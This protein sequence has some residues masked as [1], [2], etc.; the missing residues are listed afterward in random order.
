[1]PAV[2][3]T[4][5]A[6]LFGALEFS[7]YC[8]KSGIQP[9]IGCQISLART[10]Q[11][12]H[13]ARPHRR[14][15]PKTPAGMANLQRLSSLGFTT[16]DPADP[17]LPVETLLQ[18][19]DGLFLLTGGTRGPIGRLLA[20]ARRDEAASPARPLRRSLRRPQQS[21]SCTATASPSSG[22][23][24]PVL[25]PWPTKPAFPSSPPTSASSPPRRCSEAHEA[26]LCIA[27]GR[28]LADPNRRRVTDQHWFKPAAAMRKLFADL[29]EACDNTIAIA[30]RCSVMAETRK[31][32][33]PVCRK[34]REGSNEDDT[35]RAMAREGLALPHGRHRRRR[36]SPCPVFR[37]PGIRI[38][39][40]RQDGLPR[41]LP[42]RRRL[43]P[44]GQSPRH[45]RRTLA[46]APAP[47]RSPPGR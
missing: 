34:V 26:L 17:Q 32:L 21:W 40:H 23:S 9:I 46:A 11:T 30:R 13:A 37:T 2:A 33:L 29:P 24:N 43:H 18:H 16:S 39:H 10:R 8:T 38:G 22:P 20:E 28:P 41:L 6:N 35:V 45:P 31:P 1:M 36:R 4:D 27:Q 42:H 7:Q 47:A 12:R 44:M 25:S 19:A 15:S 14:S 5:T 3:I